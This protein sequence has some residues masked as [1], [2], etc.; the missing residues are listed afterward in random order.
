MHQTSIIRTNETLLI[1]HT[2]TRV[3]RHT[4]NLRPFLYATKELPSCVFGILGQSLMIY[5]SWNRLLPEETGATLSDE[6]DLPTLRVR[7]SRAGSSNWGSMVATTLPRLLAHA[8]LLL[9]DELAPFFHLG[10]IAGDV[11]LDHVCVLVQFDCFP[12]D[13]CLPKASVGLA[14]TID[15]SETCHLDWNDRPI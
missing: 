9:V 11:P 12:R 2:S 4:Q 13:Q 10:S 8:L 7:M 3:E 15:V 5:S 14:P 1:E 6:G